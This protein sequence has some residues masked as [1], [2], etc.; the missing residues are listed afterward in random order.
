[1]GGGV[2]NC[3]AS[4]RGSVLVNPVNPSKSQR[5]ASVNPFTGT[6]GQSGQS[7]SP[8]EVKSVNPSSKVGQS[9]QSGQSGVKVRG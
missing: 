8:S 9:G 7:V 4:V 6:C 2:V 3:Y 1:M 5:F